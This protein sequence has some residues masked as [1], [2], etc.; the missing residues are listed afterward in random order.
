MLAGWVLLTLITEC[1]LPAVS[2]HTLAGFGAVSIALA[3]TLQTDRFFAVF[4]LPSRQTGQLPIS[5]A[6]VVAKSVVPGCTFF[7]TTFSVVTFIADEPVRI[8]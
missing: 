7:G 3:A 4:P 5:G 8:L 1:A 2:A 6:G